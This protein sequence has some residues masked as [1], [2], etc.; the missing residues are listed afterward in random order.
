MGLKILHSAD[1]HLD[2]PFTGFDAHRR[3]LLRAALRQVPEQVAELCRR[4]EC[5]L[6]LLSGD[7]LDGQATRETLD[8]LKAALADCGVRVFIAP[9]NHDYCGPGSPWLEERWPENVHIF[10]GALE[11][12]PLPELDCRVWGGGYLAMD[13]PGLLEGFQARGPERWQLAVLHGDPTAPDSPYCPVTR[14]QVRHSGLDYLALGHI[15]KAGS[16]R[17]GDTLCGWPGCPMGRGWDET[18]EKGCC[19]LTLEDLPELTFHPLPGIRFREASAPIDRGA[20]DAL[21][22]LLPGGETQDFIRV[23]LTGT[24]QPDLEALRKEFARIP[25]LWLRDRTTPPVTLWANMDQDSL[26]GVFFRLLHTAAGGAEG[27]ERERI[28]LAAKLSR[29]LLDG[30]EVRLDDY[31]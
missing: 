26:E 21:D 2:S 11:S 3:E 19:I 1:W 23:T 24:G 7:L 30:R 18:G 14:E 13:C 28:L 27:P 20:A 5:G 16:F 9:G 25:N 4:E 15:H 29:Q 10:T 22:A 6:L 17:A 8:L 12:I 31:L